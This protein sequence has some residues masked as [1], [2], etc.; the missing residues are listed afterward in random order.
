LHMPVMDGLD[1]TELLKNDSSTKDIPIIAA[2]A[3]PIIRGK[4][5][6]DIELFDAFIPK[7]IDRE[8]LYKTLMNFIPYELSNE[9]KTDSISEIKDKR[10]ILNPSQ[11]MEKIENN[12]QPVAKDLLNTMMMSDIDDFSNELI[13][14]GKTHHADSIIDIGKKM[15]QK[16]IEFDIENLNV[17]LNQ[18]SDFKNII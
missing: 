12:F 13:E 6:K 16:V 2:S 1:A 14:L 9:E 17:L 11:L 10:K 15:K 3:S 8:R 7:P 4:N 18:I 5:V